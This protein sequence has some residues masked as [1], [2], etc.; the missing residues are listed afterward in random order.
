MFKTALYLILSL[1]WGISAVFHPETGGKITLGCSAV[2]WLALA[3][4]NIIT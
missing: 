2:V 3:V 4:Y 1:I